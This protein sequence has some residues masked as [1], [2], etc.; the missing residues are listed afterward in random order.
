MTALN[1][2]FKQKNALSLNLTPTVKGS[3]LPYED[4]IPLESSWH[5]DAMHL[6]IRILR[7]YWRN[8]NDVY[9]GG[10]MF[11]YFDPDQETYA[12]LLSNP[13]PLTVTPASGPAVLGSSAPPALPIPVENMTDILGISQVGAELLPDGPGVPSWIWQ[14]IN[15]TGEERKSA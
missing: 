12:T 8:R 1:L 4:G 7:H 14:A 15:F 11:V 2:N 3:D 9:V 6:L 10:N 13:I 5:L